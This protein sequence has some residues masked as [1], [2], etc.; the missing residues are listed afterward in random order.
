VMEGKL[1]NCLALDYPRDLLRVVVAS[2]G[3]RDATNRIVL[4]FRAQGVELVSFPEN[5]GKIAALCDAME[6]IDSEIVVLSDAGV[7]YSAQAIRKLVR[8]FADPRVGA[9][10]GKVMLRNAD[11]SYGYAEA[12]YYGIEHQIQRREG[13][14]GALV[15]ADGAMYAIRRSL[16]LPPSADTIL[17]DLVIAMGIARRGFLVVHEQEALGYEDNLLE[18]SGEFRRKVRIIAGGYQCLL[19]AANLPRLSQPLLLFCFISHKVL[20]WVSGFL[21]LALI[22]VLLQIQLASGSLFFGAL[23]GLLLTG[24]GVALLAQLF[25][26]LKG[27][28]SATVCHYF[29]MLMAASLWGGYLGVTGR[30]KVTWRGEAT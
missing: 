13:S 27:F 20:R 25:P 4:G 21:L 17:D 1:R 19:R 18:L 10:S 6:G 3:S 24:A 5:R 9:V 23:L 7:I 22:W 11:L 12:T 16:F 14:L 28:R 30:Q 26:A 2:D 8:N 15:G 29:F